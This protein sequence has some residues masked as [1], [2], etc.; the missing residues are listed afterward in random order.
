MRLTKA[1]AAAAAAALLMTAA[2]TGGS[3]SGDREPPTTGLGADPDSG[4]DPSAEAPLKIPD[5]ASEGGTLSVQSA[6]APSTLDPTQAYGKDSTGILSGLVTRSLTQLVHGDGKMVLIPDMA[7]DLGRPNAD[8]TAWTFTLRQGLKYEDGSHVRADDVAYAI[9]RSFADKELPGGPTYNQRYFLDGDTYQGPFSDGDDYA[10]VVVDGNDITIRMSRPFP[11]MDY[12]ASF[13]AF[14]AIPEDE[15][16]RDNPADYG[17]HP[18]ATGPYK[19][20]DY[21]AGSSLSLVRND[22]WE[23]RTDPGRIQSVAGWEFDF[24]QSSAKLERAIVDDSG[25]AR[26]TLTYDSVAPATYRAIQ[27]EGGDRL[28]AGSLPCTYLWYLDMRKI[29]EIEVRRAL[30]LAYPYKDAWRAAGELVGVTRQGGTS[31]LPPG[32]AGRREFDPLG[33]Q[34]TESDPKRSRALLRKAGYDPG[35]YEITWYFSSDDVTSV[36]VKDVVVSGLEAGGFKASPIVSS[37]ASVRADEKE[38]DAPVN[39]I[40]NTGWCSDWPTGGSWFP[41]QWD[42]DLVGERGRPNPS[43]IDE[44]ALDSE[45]DR[46]QELGPEEA[47]DAW[48]RFDEK[49][50]TEYYPAVNIG[51]SGQVMVFGSEV[52]GMEHDNVRGMPTFNQM[53]VIE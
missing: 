32:T 10:G 8:N 6:R 42:G 30:G 37:S 34:G 47:A 49:L 11:D 52:G 38:N 14:T 2:C 15:D 46:I 41:A 7:T 17:E 39:V 19:F 45:Q 24:G 51:Y 16:N 43:M 31:I 44:P 21:E 53:Y 3:S 50:M 18:L 25:S 20:A 40:A 9:K 33:N 27:E 12:Y 28:V 26:T 36:D 22:K 23:P 5:G 35:E 4:K 29:K 13:P 48:G 1:A